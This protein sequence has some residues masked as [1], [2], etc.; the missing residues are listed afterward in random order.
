MAKQISEEQ[1]EILSQIVPII[2]EKLGV[3]PAEVTM[4]A[5]FTN[6]LGADSLDLIELIMDFEKEYNL[7]IPDAQQE[8]IQTL[9]DVVRLIEKMQADPNW[10]PPVK[11]TQQ[12]T[13]SKVANPKTTAGAKTQKQP[14]PATVAKK[15]ART[16]TSKKVSA[17]PLQTT[18]G[19]ILEMPVEQALNL[20][21]QIRTQMALRARAGKK[22]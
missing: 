3:D 16:K 11:P 21:N 2:A 12:P 5:Q 14:K 10:V 8:E 20:F 7:S 19:E 4:D 22:K 9:G 13:A 1:Q 17:D 6:D 15:P 18:V